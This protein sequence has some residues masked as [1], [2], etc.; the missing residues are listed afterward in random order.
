MARPRNTVPTLRKHSGGQACATFVDFVDGRRVEIIFGKFRSVE[1]HRRFDQELARWIA[2]GRRLPSGD[3]PDSDGI[4]NNELLVAY[5][6]ANVGRWEKRDKKQSSEEHNTKMASKVVRE[7]Y[8]TEPARLMSP[9][10]LKAIRKA[11]IAKGWTRKQINRQANRVRRIYK[12]AVSEELIPGEVLHSLRAVNALQPGEDGVKD[13]PKV[14][15]VDEALVRHCM[16]YMQ[17]P[18]AAMVELM[19]WTGARA[20]EIVL[21]RPCDIDTS[22]EVWVY[23]PHYHKTERH[24]RERNILIGPEG[25]KILTPWLEGCEPEEYVFSPTKAEE[26]R[27]AERAANRKTPRWKSHMARNARKRVGN[28]RKRKPGHRY[29]VDAFR[30]AV[31][32]SVY[33]ADLIARKARDDAKRA[34]GEEVP[35]TRYRV[36]KD[37]RIVPS[38]HPHQL[39]HTAATRLRKQYGVEM[40]RV[41]LGHSSIEVSELYAEID[42]EAAKEAMKKSG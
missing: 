26:M 32:Y 2:A 28:R 8:G 16:G 22:G 24:G 5:F 9:K 41:V 13:R 33:K 10:R 35:K 14:K 27:L 3:E 17:K 37:E 4:S 11:M 6:D 23:R 18:V 7:L 39:R 25:Q 42:I 20:G 36:K 15:P 1:A 31:V 19:L 21:L 38:W 34:G 29:D 40:A 12:W 30:R